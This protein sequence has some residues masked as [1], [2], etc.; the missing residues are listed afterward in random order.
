[1]SY[2]K[3]EAWRRLI[4]RTEE[5]ARA[6]EAHQK[7]K[8][9]TGT[10]YLCTD[11]NTIEA[12]AHWRRIPNA[13]PYD[14]YFVKSDMLVLKRHSDE[15]GLSNEER[16][17]LTTLKETLSGDYDHLLENLPRQQSIPHHYHIHLVTFAR[18]TAA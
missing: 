16:E 1:M 2:Q 7:E 3:Q 9:G 11:P 10:C 6:Y 18:P 8:C 14:R 5:T 17:E 13:Y 15:R 4:L 12:Y